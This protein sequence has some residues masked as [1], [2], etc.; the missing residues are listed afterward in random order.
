VWFE[1]VLEFN[2][3]KRY[4]ADHFLGIRKFEFIFGRRKENYKGGGKGSTISSNKE[5]RSKLKMLTVVS[6]ENR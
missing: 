5:S 3:R 4:R 2:I 1:R 6:E